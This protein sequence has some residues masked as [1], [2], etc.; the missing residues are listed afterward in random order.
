MEEGR[1][2]RREERGRRLT[3]LHS[4]DACGA[5]QSLVLSG[6]QWNATDDQRL[7]SLAVHLSLEAAQHVRDHTSPGC[8]E[9]GEPEEGAVL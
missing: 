4:W 5:E 7:E 3:S 6:A 9:S 2:G 1:E 8:L